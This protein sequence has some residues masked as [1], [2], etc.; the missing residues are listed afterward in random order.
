MQLILSRW[1]NSLA[2]RIPA[3]LVRDLA[4][5]EGASVECQATAEGIL[6]IIPTSQKAREQWLGNH[7][8][9]L[10]VQLET[11]PLTTPASDLLRREERY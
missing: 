3:E 5:E 2:V 7:F 6:E 9:M 4:L 11:Q 8:A 10:N 1:G